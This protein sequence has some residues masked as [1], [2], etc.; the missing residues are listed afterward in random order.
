MIWLFPA[1]LPNPHGLV[2][3]RTHACS[4][5]E[6]EYTV[7]NST[8]ISIP[9]CI[10]SSEAKIL[11]TYPQVI[12][13]SSY[14][15][16]S[17]LLVLSVTEK[18]DPKDKS[19]KRQFRLTNFCPQGNIVSSLKLDGFKDIQLRRMLEPDFSPPAYLRRDLSACAVMLPREE[20]GTY[21]LYT[22]KRNQPSTVTVQSSKDNQ[23]KNML[24]ECS[25]VR[26]GMFLFEDYDPSIL[27]EDLVV[28]VSSEKKLTTLRLGPVKPLQASSAIKETPLSVVNE[29][30]LLPHCPSSGQWH[31]VA[32]L[33]LCSYIGQE[34]EATGINLCVVMRPGR[35]L[36]LKLTLATGV[37]SLLRVLVI[38]SD[39]ITTPI[40]SPIKLCADPRTI[41][42]CWENTAVQYDKI[43]GVWES[44]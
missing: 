9:A 21:L 32:V 23:N 34:K 17:S 41:R 14:S 15:T 7:W 39:T 42:V 29:F 4:N 28:C 27:Y 40:T 22:C 12:T 31:P 1:A 19:L 37:I 25:V 38:P 36:L 20:S 6:G 33:P 24:H 44:L 2:G 5:Q 16:S 30:N 11:R 18:E 26:F 13:P 43:S 10:D 35:L 8:Q 3:V